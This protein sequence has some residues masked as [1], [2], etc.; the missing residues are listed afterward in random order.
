MKALLLA[1][2]SLVCLSGCVSLEEKR[3]LYM[4]AHPDLAGYKVDAMKRTP[5]AAV[6]GMTLEEV[7]L[8][9]GPRIYRRASYSDGTT[10][11]RSGSSVL[12]YFREGQLSYWS[13]YR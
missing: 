9:L 1:A 7:K 13:S 8:V 11:Y 12:L 4:E 2:L 3:A 10:V 6:P 5:A